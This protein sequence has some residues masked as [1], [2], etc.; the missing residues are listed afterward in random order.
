MHNDIKLDYGTDFPKMI[1]NNNAN[2]ALVERMYQFFHNCIVQK[3]VLAFYLLLKLPQIL[4]VLIAW[5]LPRKSFIKKKEDNHRR[6]IILENL[7]MS[8]LDAG[9]Q[10]QVQVTRISRAT[11]L[12]LPKCRYKI[13]IESSLSTSY[14]L[15]KHKSRRFFFFSC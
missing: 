13:D 14:Q 9:L 7:G 4:R 11:K 8:L 15:S 6:R 12:S 1:L 2:K 3:K 10:R 5:Y